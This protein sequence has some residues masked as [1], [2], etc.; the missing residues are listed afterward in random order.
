M[1]EI[2]AQ[3]VQPKIKMPNRQLFS[4]SLREI[5][6]G[7]LWPIS[8]A[9]TLII[10]CIFALTALADR[11][12][13][14]IVKQG[15]DAL[16]ADS[17][18]VSANPIPELLLGQVRD[19]NLE[20]T[21]LTRFATMAFS[22]E[23]MQLVTVK[24]VGDA[25][26]L[27]GELILTDESGNK[28]SVSQGELWLEQRV[29]DQL[30]V[31]IGDSVTI[32]DADLQ[33]TGVITE[34]PGLSFNPF[35]QMPSVMINSADIEKTGALQIGSRVQFR[36]FLNGD[37]NA[38]QSIV[39][40][41]ELTPSDRWLTENT[42]SRTSDVFSRTKQ[43]L[44]LT[45]AIVILMAA[46]TLVLTCQHYVSNRRQTIAMLKSIGASKNWIA[47][48]LWVQLGVLFAIGIT[49][50]IA[51]GIG[52]EVLLRLPMADLLPDPLPSYG[53]SPYL[54]SVVTCVLISVPALGIPLLHLLNTPALSVMQDSALKVNRKSL[55][56]L[57][58]PV[59]PMLV[60]YGSNLMVWMVLVGIVVLFAVL[61]LVSSLL[62]RLVSKLP[63]NTT[64]KLAVSRLNRTSVASGVQFAALA[65]S[66]MLLSVIW[67]VRTDLLSDWQ[68]TLPDDAPNVFALNIASTEVD[69]YL[70]TLDE[71]VQDR[72]E[73][74]PIIR[75]RVSTING[76][77][78]K[79]YVLS[80]R[81]AEEETDA[82]SR[83]LNFTW[84]DQIPAHN[85][86]LEG[87]WVGKG[88]VSVESD[89]M[90][91]LGLEIGDT[92]TYVINGVTVE[93]KVDSV[94]HV[95]W[96]EMKPNFYFIFS[97]DVLESI[98]STYL[99]SFRINDEQ[100]PFLNQLSR[101]Y[102]T[103][104]VMD[105][106][107]M[108]AKIQELLRQIV[109]A[110]TVL[111]ALGVIAGLMLIFTLLRLSLSQRQQE[112]RLYRTLG[113]SKKRISNTLWCEFGLMAIIAGIIA[114]FGAEVSVAS[115]MKWGF[116]LTPNAHPW[117]WLILPVLSF[118]TL[119]LVLNT[120]IKRLLI[121]VNK[122]AY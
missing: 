109:W 80:K 60:V 99:V 66:L 50:G 14:I 62:T 2:Q 24:A 56:L 85:D 61:G 30:N 27:R 45:V 9:L 114:S 110:I 47:R 37:S 105:I 86:L 122:G 12:E 71:N 5:R 17:V 95:E 31:K 25:Y 52:L 112:I 118:A 113:A 76:I 108:G 88:S 43:Y 59:I 3:V 70:T 6:Q 100:K 21:T 46:T 41:T 44:S 116:E 73:A 16:T 89:V 15:K 91:E 104:S 74:Y 84:A 10:A 111:A 11:M 115:L 102:P 107:T 39:D 69:S 58:V 32:G 94:R 34:E 93:A 96:R 117:L 67:L 29:M 22:D 53:I 79:D 33:V 81:G 35:Q 7:Q 106:S 72:S 13:Q 42:Q 97:P 78:A 64:M 55:L 19:N 26:P 20:T 63:M 101:S 49:F 98:P 54:Y 120:L 68:Q 40:S 57:L 38:I 23:D 90:S 121:P 51:I 1:E 75:G 65:L 28:S 18:F 77:P 119:G 103:V 87:E 83:E 8:A 36:L 92:L 4:W 48:W 82:L